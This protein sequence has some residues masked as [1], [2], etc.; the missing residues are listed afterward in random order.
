V[1]LLAGLDLTARP[2][3]VAGAG[4]VG[5][6]RAR[7]A[8]AAGALVHVVAPEASDDVAA[9]A[10]ADRLRLDRRAVRED[11]L[12][13]VW[14]VLACTGDAAADAALARWAED[15]RVFCVVA[16]DAGAG[17]ARLPAT[18][19][20]GGLQLG[21]LSDGSPDPRRVVAVRDHLAEEV[22]RGRVDLDA[23]RTD[24]SGPDVL[25]P[26]EVAL[27]GG[28]TGDPA[29]MTVR[30]RT[31]LAQADVV[32]ADRLGPAAV[33]D[34]LADDVRVIPVGKAPGA[35]HVS[36]ERIQEILVEQARAGHRV[37]RLKGGD[38]FLFGRGGEEVLACREAG[39]PVRVVPGVTSAIAAA[40]G[41]DIPVTHRG[42]SDR[43]HVVNGHWPLTAL[44]L[45]A[46]RSPDVTVVVLMGVATLPDLVAQALAAG[47]DPALPAAVVA[48]ATLPGERTVR[49]P[50]VDLPAICAHAGVRSPGV[51]VLGQVARPGF[52]D[53]ASAGRAIA[54]LSRAEREALRAAGVREPEPARA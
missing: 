39:V 54:P 43:V 42:T 47:V 48:R 50:L 46:L 26:G 41:A 11:D 12:A 29:L 23:R 53:P 30:A 22:R 13:D 8:L 35:P 40:A 34:E 52:L 5:T 20:V 9:W 6:R 25:L 4:P 28:G 51:V 18:A 49:G 38:P 37:V 14:L 36:Q 15:R 7:A 44:D 2:V 27:V 32:V 33:L 24:A 1:T 31:L 45:H 3:L 16:A 10:A 17:S 21:V 19:H